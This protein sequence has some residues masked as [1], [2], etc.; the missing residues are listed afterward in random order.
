VRIPDELWSD[1]RDRELVGQTT[2]LFAAVPLVLTDRL[3]NSVWFNAPAEA[4]FRDR[5]EAIV[6]RAAWSLLGFG[7]AAAAPDRLMAALLGEGPP[8]KGMVRPEGNPAARP[9]FC[10]ASA[11]VREGRLVCGILRFLPTE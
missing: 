3:S 8:W 7:F 4:L 6:N 11:L 9:E 10:E 1:A 5:A 2:E